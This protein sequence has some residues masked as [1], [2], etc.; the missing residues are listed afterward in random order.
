MS[1]DNYASVTS[2]VFDV[3]RCLNN[4]RLCVRLSPDG[5]V[6]PEGQPKMTKDEFASWVRKQD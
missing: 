2:V 6:K 3:E 5:T 1:K 4:L